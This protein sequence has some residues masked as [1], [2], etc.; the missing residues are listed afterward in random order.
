MAYGSG[1]VPGYGTRYCIRTD[2][3]VSLSSTKNNR[4]ED[5]ADPVFPG[6]AAR[7]SHG[8]PWIQRRVC[9]MD[10]LDAPE[11][12]HCHENNSNNTTSTYSPM[13]SSMPAPPTMSS[14]A[15]SIA[16]VDV[17]VNIHM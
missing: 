8:F 3:V 11:W 6:V 2:N 14:P 16:T 9:A 4:G 5:C 7:A 17:V 10:G 13:P 12:F 15:P 1:S